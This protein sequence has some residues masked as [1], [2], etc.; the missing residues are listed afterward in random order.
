MTIESLDSQ[1]RKLVVAT[2]SLV[3]YRKNIAG[4]TYSLSKSLGKLSAFFP[5]RIHGK[6]PFRGKFP[7]F[8]TMCLQDFCRVQRRT[9]SCLLPFNSSRRLKR[10]WVVTSD[11]VWMLEFYVSIGKRNELTSY[12]IAIAPNETITNMGYYSIYL[13]W[14]NSRLRRCTSN[15]LRTTS[16]W[17]P[18]WW[19]T[20][21]G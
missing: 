20:T 13:L 17:C 8:F 21:L 14:A 3:D 5:G 4:H 9:A 2:D 6:N 15:R 7:R 11:E 10:R 18:S 1:L 12:K 19:E 16:S